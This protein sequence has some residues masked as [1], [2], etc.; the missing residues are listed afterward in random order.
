VS[1]PLNLSGRRLVVTGAA[2]GIGFA[3]ARRLAEAG[4]VVVLADVRADKAAVAASAI[5]QVGLVAESAQVDVTSWQSCVQ[6]AE[7]VAARGPVDGLVNSAA[8]WT[9]GPFVDMDPEAWQQDIRVTLVGSMLVSQALLPSLR[10]PGTASIVNIGSDA[11]RVGE[12]GQVAYSAAK[13]GIIGFT[14]A[15][16]REEGRHGIRVNCVSPGLTRTPA[17]AAFIDAMTAADVARAYPLGRLGEPV[18]VADLVLFLSSDLSTWV[19][20]QT[21]SVS[22]GYT[23]AG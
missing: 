11:G 7:T 13:A 23:T 12:R 8:T 14:K 3:C 18:D 19:T 9:L 6:L 5:R 21:V 2:S 4:A 15:L 20:G 10:A 16:A 1:V 22:G 17:S